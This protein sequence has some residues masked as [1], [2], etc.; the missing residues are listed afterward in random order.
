MRYQGDIYRPPSEAYSLL[1]QATIGCSHN[2]CAF[3]SMFRGK[4][5]SMRKI[6]DVLEDIEEARKIYPRIE[7]IFLTDGNALVLPTDYLVQLL[8]KIKDLFPECLRVTVY[9]SA[10]DILRKS[11]EELALL[12]GLGLAMVYV[13]LESGNEEILKHVNKGTTAASIVEAVQKAKAAGIKTSVTVISGLGGIENSHAHAVDTA[14]AVTA[15]DPDYLGLL[16]LTVERGT[17][18]YDWINSGKFV[19]PDARGI[20]KETRTMV[21]HMT[22]TECVFRSNHISNYVPFA[23]TLDRD[24]EALLRQIDSLLSGEHYFTRREML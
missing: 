15:M 4:T 23:A 19:L 1:I 9:A 2:K 18:M 6:E 21:E 22:L 10:P 3:C 11:G 16:T 13:G 5:F 17:P 7:K 20:L 8:T 24:K 14:K 12:R